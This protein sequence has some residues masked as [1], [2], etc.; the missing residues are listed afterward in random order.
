MQYIKQYIEQNKQRLLDELF[1]LLRFPSVSADPKYAPDVLNTAEH[2]AKKLRDAGADKVEVCQT[3]GYP[4]VYGEK[5]IDP[6]KPTILVYGHYDVQP[7]DPLELWHSGPFEPVVKDGR[8]YAR[9][10]ADD[11]G[12]VHMHIKAFET[13]VRTGT[14]S[15]NVKFIIEGEEE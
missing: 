8:L 5:I 2:V 11:K 9:G 6:A 14:L 13:M 3:A 7:P 15:C 10:S 12:Q 1:E 4:I